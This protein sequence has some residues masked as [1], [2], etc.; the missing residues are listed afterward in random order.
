[1]IISRRM[2]WVWHVASME[3]RNA[4][5][6]SI[7]HD[8]GNGEKITLKLNLDKQHQVVWT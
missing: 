4:Y 7:G 6:V 1:M 5:M 2:K 8:L 3:K